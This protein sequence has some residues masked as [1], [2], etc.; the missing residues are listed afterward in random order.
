MQFIRN[1]VLSLDQ[2]QPFPGN[3]RRGD[4]DAIAE[5]LATFGQYRSLIVREHE[6][7]HVI[8]A[9][10][11]TAQGIARLATYTAGQLDEIYGAGTAERWG[12]Q[13]KAEAR[14]EIITCDDGEARK[15]NAADNRLA[16]LGGY[17]DAA[18]L[19]QLQQM[20]GDMAGTGWTEDDLRRLADPIPAPGTFVEFGQDI[21]TDYRCPQC[22]Y[23]WSGKAK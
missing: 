2:L 13:V 4:V 21:E 5:S 11:H 8:L 1:D 6:G 18:L 12:G 23:E 3:A 14:V 16:E 9:G 17:D 15:I 7:A 20:S 10:N 22:S 19:A